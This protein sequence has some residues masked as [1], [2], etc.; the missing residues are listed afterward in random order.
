MTTEVS[1]QSLATD[2]IY[3]LGKGPS[4]ESFDLDTI[5]PDARVLGINE[6]AYNY[7]RCTDAFAI[8]YP[9]LDAYKLFL[10]P[11][12]HVFL[13]NTHIGY[14]FPKYTHWDH[15]KVKP[16]TGSINPCIRMLTMLGFRRFFLI[17][18]D[19]LYGDYSRN[20]KYEQDAKSKSY[21]R[22]NAALLLTAANWPA[23]IM[24]WSP[25]SHTFE[26]LTCT[27]YYVSTRK[28]LPIKS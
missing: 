23:E 21:D 19:S 9:V 1:E 28:A 25:E 27:P 5:P 26:E 24:V 4:L 14:T 13:K 17:G 12:V 10:P 7:P 20:S 8:D 6:T 2:T 18:F 22:I 3:I 15:Q 16:Y 11:S